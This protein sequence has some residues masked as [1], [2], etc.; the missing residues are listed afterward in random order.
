MIYNYPFF[1]LSTDPLNCDLMNDANVNT[2]VLLETDRNPSAV[3]KS[4]V[5]HHHTDH[6]LQVCS[7]ELII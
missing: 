3:G 7:L 2:R 4:L 1:S 6:Q 5:F